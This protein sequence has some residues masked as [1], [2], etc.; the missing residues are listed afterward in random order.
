LQ[1]TIDHDL[2]RPQVN[3][4][5]NGRGWRVARFPATEVFGDPA[6]VAAELRALLRQ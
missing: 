1:L 5:D 6:H 4:Y 2:A 3:R